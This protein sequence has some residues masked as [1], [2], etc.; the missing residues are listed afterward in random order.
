MADTIKI[1]CNQCNELR[2]DQPDA[3]IT[4]ATLAPYLSAA[5][6]GAVR[7]L[8]MKFADFP[9]SAAGKAITGARFGL[10]SALFYTNSSG[11]FLGFDINHVERED[12][13]P[14]T[15]ET[16]AW[17]NLYAEVTRIGGIPNASIGVP[18]WK[19]LD[20]DLN[21]FKEWFP[22]VQSRDFMSY[23]HVY[24]TP[25]RP[26][27]ASDI[28]YTQVRTN[29]YSGF[30]PYLE[31]DLENP[32]LAMYVK[33]LPVFVDAT[34][35]ATFEW[36]AEDFEGRY[37]IGG[38][39]FTG[40]TFSWGVDSDDEN[41]I[42]VPAPHNFLAVPAGTFPEGKEIKYKISVTTAASSA[43]FT[44][45]FSTS[46]TLPRSAP[47]Y[48]RRNY[49]AINE[50]IT[51]MWSH[52]ND[53][54]TAPSKSEL[55][56]ST[57]GSTFEFLASVLGSDLSITI[58]ANTLPSGNLWWHV[59]TFSKTGDPGPWSDA[60][61]FVGRGAPAVPAIVA[62]SNEPRPTVNWQ[63][64]GQ[65]SYRLTV[66]KDD[67]VIYDTGEIAGEDH[68]HMV[69]DYLALGTYTVAVAVKNTDQLWSEWATQTITLDYPA[70]IPPTISAQSIKNGALIIVET[71]PMDAQYLYL[72]RDGVPI[73][74]IDKGTMQYIDY[75]W[76][77][78]ALYVVRA[79][80]SADLF[81]D[82]EAVLCE[83]K[84]DCAQIAPADAPEDMLMMAM[85]PAGQPAFSRRKTYEASK[86]RYAGREHPVITYSGFAD[87][88]YTPSFS[89]DTTGD[90]RKLNAMADVRG[91]IL[92]RD[93]MGNRYY[94]AIT[95]ITETQE[96]YDNQ[97][98]CSRHDFSLTISRVS[99]VE[100]IEYL[101]PMP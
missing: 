84:I 54:G 29:L 34:E 1:L 20:L 95:G 37:V 43:E 72:L 74:L 61:P 62:I 65:V 55:R 73:A 98:G 99:H 53:S 93:C 8:A 87:E 16:G 88:E 69:Q 100:K 32:E 41:T 83:T 15:S 96:V 40:A 89:F 60:V 23:L 27:S 63:A 94:G 46:D 47:D 38:I 12:K 5:G 3:A 21:D 36:R 35:I 10:Y 33:S 18:A 81:A 68:A 59:R 66:T 78:S 75:A 44:G 48:P 64:V 67:A 22:L 79:V 6:G 57:D 30:E 77:G 31:F 14:W 26:L 13:P 28:A 51:F 101:E 45:T 19:T 9:A 7:A 24:P 86:Q 39:S 76:N 92:Y 17:N 90:M 52:R 82:S 85:Y 42:A 58:G 4:G 25:T 71:S 70:V 11:L 80:T 91:T 56:Y 2:S 97:D 49:V 50:P